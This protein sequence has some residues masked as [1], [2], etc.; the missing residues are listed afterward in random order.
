[1]FI[2]ALHGDPALDI[3]DIPGIAYLSKS[4]SYSFVLQH[5]DNH[6]VYT[7]PTPSATLVAIYELYNSDDAGNECM[8]FDDEETKTCR[9]TSLPRV[10]YVGPQETEIWTNAQSCLACNALHIIPDI[11]SYDGLDS[12][13]KHIVLSRTNAPIRN[14][15]RLNN[16]PMSPYYPMG[17]MLTHAYTGERVSIENPNYARLRDLRGNNPNLQYHYL[18]LY[19]IGKVT[20]FLD[21]FPMYKS[22]FYDFYTNYHSFITDVHNAYVSY[23]VLKEGRLLPKKYFIHAAK[24]HHDVYLPSLTAG[25]KTI[26]THRVVREYFDTFTPSKMLY[27]L[28]YEDVAR[29]EANSQSVDVSTETM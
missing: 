7:I 12:V 5:P 2:D 1:M 6:M 13:T 20:E 26:I 19:R 22:Q 14:S 4:H 16:K 10:R 23:Y 15:L 27:Y 29:E 17:W 28:R 21:C 3:N 11:V 18:S 9:W 25:N 8:F 24:I